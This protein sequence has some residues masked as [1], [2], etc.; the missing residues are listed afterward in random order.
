MDHGAGGRHL[1]DDLLRAGKEGAALVGNGDLSRGAL[2]EP[3]AQVRL[4]NLE[5]T[6]DT[7]RGQGQFLR[8]AAH[9]QNPRK[10]QEDPQLLAVDGGFQG[11]GRN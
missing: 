3:A 11:R 9:V 7:R 5:A 1:V 6:A 8:G 2:E 10:G 4:K